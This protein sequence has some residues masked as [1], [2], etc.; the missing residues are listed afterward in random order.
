MIKK[1]ITFVILSF[2]VT[3]S[4]NAAIPEVKEVKSEGG[5][6]AWMIEDSYLPIVSIKIAFSKSGYAYDPS[7]KKGLAYMVSGLLDEGAG[8][9]SSLEYRKKL[10]ELATTIS[11]SADKDNFYISIKTLKENLEESIKL[12]NLTLT[13]PNLK[14][15]VI[16]RIR[17]QILVIIN[18]KNEQP[19]YIA[20]RE[21]DE[22]IFGKQPYANSKYGSLN[23]VKAINR[24]DLFSFLDNFSKENIIISVV[25]DTSSSKVKKLLDRHLK[26]PDK[27]ADVNEVL[28]IEVNEKAKR[29]DIEKDIAQ[30]IVVFGGKAIK[31]SDKDFYAVYLM[32]RILGGGGFES[33][34]MDTVRVKHGLAYSIYTYLDAYKNT[35]LF[36]GKVGTDASKREKTIKLIKSEIK[37][38]QKKGVTQEELDDAKN[39]LVNSFPLRMTKNEN[40]A[41]HLSVMQIYN[42][43]ID[44]LEKRNQYVQSVTVEQI[45]KVAKQILDVD[46]M[47]F[48]VVGN[49]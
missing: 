13:K 9:I 2:F 49:K 22:A 4:S 16:E 8:G 39:Y 45:N 6:K 11:F 48:V 35:G 29:I 3:I 17:N 14:P 43:G 38:M 30:S 36:V 21:F 19:Q 23:S 5:Y 24:D 28:K 10:Q 41:T 20:S 15:D 27:G 33:R 25:G 37:K 1:I 47:T 46:N 34:L 40:L 32:N 12:L 44:F 42:L 18:K 26:L 31:R 7:D